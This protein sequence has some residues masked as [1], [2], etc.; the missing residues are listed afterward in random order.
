MFRTWR[1]AEKFGLVLLMLIGGMIIAGALQKLSSGPPGAIYFAPGEPP[2][3]ALTFETLWSSDG[4]ENLLHLLQEE[5]VQATFFLTGIWLENNVETAKAILERG[6]EIGNHTLNHAN[7]LYATG[8]EIVREI[9]G[10]N[11]AAQ[12]TLEYSPRLFRPPQGLYNGAVLEQAGR[13][14]CRTVLWS[15]ESY[16]YISQDAAEVSARVSKRLQGGAIINFRAG[17]PLLLKALPKILQMV[18]GRGL[19]AVKVSD[20]LKSRTWPGPAVGR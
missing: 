9:E 18:R 3:V 10:F 8:E 5:E 13:C 6:H 17:S 7:L 2:Q 20:L 15:V 16:D 1:R 14:R 12:D 11:E 19:E 4:V